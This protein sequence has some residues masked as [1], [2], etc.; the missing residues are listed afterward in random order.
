S[1]VRDP[2]VVEAA[3]DTKSSKSAP[4][5]RK[6]SAEHKSSASTQTTPARPETSKPEISKAEAAP[7]TVPAPP[8]EVKSPELVDLVT[9]CEQC[10]SELGADDIFCGECGY[11]TRSASAHFSR[12]RDTAIIQAVQ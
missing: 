12:T 6:V 10:G 11:V 8:V 2:V 1:L 3:R 4:R 5:A 9:R 7:K